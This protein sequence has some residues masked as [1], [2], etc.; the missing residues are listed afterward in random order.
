MEPGSREESQALAFLG[1]LANCGGHK[2]RPPSYLTLQNIQLLEMRIGSGKAARAAMEP[3]ELRDE[4]NVYLFLQAA[5]GPAVE[6]A[7]RAFR[8][9]RKTKPR[10]EAWED[11]MCEAV[12]PFLGT[13][14]PEIRADLEEQLDTLGEI[15]ANT[16]NAEPPPGQKASRPD[17][18]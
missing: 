10:D 12:A 8:R 3:D 6:R 15:P 13:L 14:T 1:L 2:L 5:P 7:L 18:N 17:P 16:V 9:N 4:V 11:F